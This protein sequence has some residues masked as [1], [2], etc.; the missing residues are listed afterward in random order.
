M[1]YLMYVEPVPDILYMD[2]L[3]SAS[4]V[5]V[6]KERADGDV[7]RAIGLQSAV[8]LKPKLV[9]WVTKGKPNV[10]PI[11]EVAIEPPTRCSDGVERN[12]PD[13]IEFCSGHPIAHHMALIQV[14]LIGM[15]LSYMRIGNN[16]AIVV[17]QP[18]ST[19]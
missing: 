2:D 3:V 19:A 12:L 9:E 10:F 4:E 18:S 17:S 8:S 5:L 15:A 14:K 6:A 7:I 1:P 11:I 13:Y 16:V